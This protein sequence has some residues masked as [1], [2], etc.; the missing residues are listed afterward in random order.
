MKLWNNVINDTCDIEKFKEE[1]GGQN[2]I[3]LK[4]YFL[5]EYEQVIKY[6]PSKDYRF[7]YPLNLMQKLT[8]FKLLKNKR[9]GNWS[10]TGA[11]KTLSFIVS[12][13]EVDSRLTLMI[14]L[15]ST[16]NQI[17][18]DI[19]QTYPDSMVYMYYKRGYVFDRQHHNYLIL[20]Y[21]K[22]QQHYSEEIFQNLTD[23]NKIDFIVIDEV[24]NV[25]QRNPENETIRRGTIKRLIGR[26]AEVNKDLFVLGMS[27]T[28]VI[29]NLTEAKSLL[30]MINGRDYSELNT[31]KSIH[32][33]LEIFKHITIN[34]LRYIP[35]YKMHM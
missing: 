31:Y 5:D 4:K 6:H 15:N 21:D 10:G 35:K 14:C 18:E 8:V 19:L 32:N 25:K 34:G 23:N 24:H 30:E 20:N 16:I 33:A 22:F 28:P 12:S 11:G 13:R 17:K 7:P 29:N 27:A 3:L 9:Y 2:F 26:A 1:E